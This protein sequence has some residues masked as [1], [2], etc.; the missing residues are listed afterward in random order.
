MK[1]Y[2]KTERT[3]YGGRI[4][5][6][7]SAAAVGFVLFLASFGVLWFNEGRS[8]DRIKTLN[9]GQNS[10]VSVASDAVNPQNTGALVYLSGLA[11]TPDVLVDAELGLGFDGLRVRRV[12]EMYQWQ[13]NKKTTTRDEL[14]GGQ[15]TTTEYTYTSKWS[16]TVINST[17]FEESR[18]YRN[19]SQKP[20]ADRT[21]NANDVTL[22]AFPVSGAV[23]EKMSAFETLPMTTALL[24]QANGRNAAMFEADGR[25]FTNTVNM[26]SPS[27]GDIRMW[28]EVVPETTF[29]VVAQQSDGGMLTEAILPRGNLLLVESGQIPLENMFENARSENTLFTWLL[30]ALGFFLMFG[31]LVAMLS[32]LAALGYV[33]PFIGKVLEAGTKF[34][35]FIIALPLTLITIALA[36]LFFRPLIGLI[37]LAIA[38]FIAVGG[39]GMARK[40]IAGKRAAAEDG[41]DYDNQGAVTGM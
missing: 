28:Y 31:G 9:A 14:G 41:D 11:S 18:R 19:P 12:V 35:A 26:S 29:S 16:R 27:I 21:I 8:V 22:G 20:I 15:T 2:V 39:I 33:V 6:A 7:F 25:Y 1:R 38:I 40:F 37:L 4:G 23:V 36:W 13:E 5:K 24:A 3:S 10:T 17:R 30:R 34:I 32:P